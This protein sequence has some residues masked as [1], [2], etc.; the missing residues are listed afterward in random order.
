MACAEKNQAITIPW[1]NWLETYIKP[2]Y[3]LNPLINGINN[4][5]IKSYPFPIIFWTVEPRED[6]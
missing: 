2:S 5:H 6:K 3:F 4:L 1:F